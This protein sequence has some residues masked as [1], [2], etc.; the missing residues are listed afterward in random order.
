MSEPYSPL[1]YPGGKAKLANFLIAVMRMNRIRPTQYVEPYA[2][3]AGAA[4]RLLFEE[5]VDRIWIH[6]ADP[7]ILCFW[8]ALTEENEEFVKRLKTVEVSVAEWHKQRRVYDA[9]NVNRPCTLGFATFYL[10]RTSRSGIIH[11]GGPIGGYDQKGNYLI[12]ARFNRDQ[13]V[14]RVQRI[15]I[16]ADRITVSGIDG[17][18]LLKKMNRSPAKAQSQFVYL[19]PPYHA[20]GPELYMDRF[21]TKQHE[22]LAKYLSLP[23]AFN[24]IMTYDDVDAIRQLYKTFPKFRFSLEYSVS[25]RRKGHELLIHTKSVTVPPKVKT[26]LPYVA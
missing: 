24:W 7:R 20:K 4:L 25:G 14:R 18:A 6:D 10:N 22:Q 8:R 1:R 17:L 5:Y 16:Y 19:D 3:G 26:A 12:D 15:G 23:K 2:G 21:T 11:N 9:C 13:L